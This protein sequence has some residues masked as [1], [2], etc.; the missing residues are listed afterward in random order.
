M[1]DDTKSKRTNFSVF[2]GFRGLVVYYLI[3][4]MSSANMLLGS[5]TGLNPNLKRC[6][7]GVL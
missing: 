5:G 3:P 7:L 2:T 6:E 4:Q 1:K